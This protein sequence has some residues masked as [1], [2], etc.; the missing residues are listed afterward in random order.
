[1]FTGLMHGVTRKSVDIVAQLL[2][3][4]ALFVLAIG[5]VTLVI[6][7]I[8]T[9]TVATGL[10]MAFVNGTLPLMAFSVIIMRGYELVKTIKRPASSFLAKPKE[11]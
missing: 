2:A 1:M 9:N 10:N 4:A 7:T 3:L 5:G 8:D 11:L 6:Q